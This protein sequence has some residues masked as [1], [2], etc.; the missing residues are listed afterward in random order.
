ME[1]IKKGDLADFIV[2]IKRFSK[3]QV[4]NLMHCE[5]RFG[6]SLIHQCVYFGHLPILKYLIDYFKQM[7][8]SI[9]K[10]N[11]KIMEQN[12]SH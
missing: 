9:L 3:P 5:D 6:Y 11:S 8:K 12:K 4:F 7:V 2:C 1:A 10:S